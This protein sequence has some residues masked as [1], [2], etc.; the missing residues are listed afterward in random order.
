MVSK[1]YKSS[2]IAYHGVLQDD[3]P[4]ATWAIEIQHQWVTE[5]R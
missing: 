3:T 2:G 4:R 5:Y 1:N